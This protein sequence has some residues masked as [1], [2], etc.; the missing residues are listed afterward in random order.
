MPKKIFIFLIKIYQLTISPLLGLTCRFYPSCSH[1][2][3]EALQK[4]GIFKGAWL[5]LKRIA[6]CHPWNP[7][8]HDPVP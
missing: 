7:G 2:M 6:R 5:G 3:I 1:Y 4:H 8:G